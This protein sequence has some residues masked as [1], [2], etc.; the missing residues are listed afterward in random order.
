M[1][2]N[3]DADLLERTLEECERAI[4][5][6]ASAVDSDPERLRALLEQ[7]EHLLALAKHDL[8]RPPI[9]SEGG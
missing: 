5:E 3:S 2:I 1:T 4:R 6:A 8:C 9:S 7:A